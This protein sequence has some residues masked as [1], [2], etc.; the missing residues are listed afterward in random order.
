[1]REFKE[2]IQYLFPHVTRRKVKT[3]GENNNVSVITMFDGI[4]I[5]PLESISYKADPPLDIHLLLDLLPENY[6]YYYYYYY[7]YSLLPENCA[8]A[9]FYKSRFVVSCHQTTYP[10]GIP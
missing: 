5:K 7:Y 2:T 4:N 8:H 3:T 1:M 6:Y 9:F 10:T